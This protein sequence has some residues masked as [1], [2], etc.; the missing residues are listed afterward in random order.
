[1][2]K[3]KSYALK[4]AAMGF[5]AIATSLVI[6]LS[7]GCAQT[8]KP[9]ED[10][11]DK[12][13]TKLDSQ[14][15]K[16]GNFEFYSDN[17][18]LYPI[19][20]PDN[21]SGGTN[22][23]S[24]SS[25]SGVIDTSKKRWD[26]LTDT[27]LPKTLEDNNDLKSDDENKKD[28]NGA[29]TDDLP[30][31]NPHK[32]T[33]SSASDEDKEYIHNPYTHKYSY[34]NQGRIIDSADDSVVTTYEDEDGKLY[35][36]EKL[37]T[38]L[39]S[40]V[41]MI[42][43][44][45]NN[46]YTGTEGYFSSSTTTTLE[47]GTAA[48]ISLWVKT[49]D[50]YFDG[51]TGTRT[52]V[53]SER[54]AYIKVNTQVGGNSLES[55]IIKNIDT[56]KVNADGA[57]NGWVQYT[58]YVEASNFADTTVSLTLGLGQDD[59][60]TV[61]G[62]AFF[63]DVTLTKY[64]NRAEM[65]EKCAAFKEKIDTANG[66]NVSYPLSPDDAKTEFRVDKETYQ[67]NGTDGGYVERVDE[68]NFADR[69]FFIDLASSTAEDALAISASGIT[70]GLTVEE[71]STGKYVSA[72]NDGDNKY[73]SDFGALENGAATAFIPNKLGKNGINI[74]DDLL[75]YTTV[76][77]SADWKLDA[78]DYTDV[79]TDALN[80][81]VKLPG[82]QNNST[83]ALVILSARGAGYEAQIT[84][85]EKF[86]LG[87][88][89][90]ALISFWVKTSDMN[91]ASAARFTVIDTEDKTKKSEFSVD[92]TTEAFVDIGDKE[93]VYNG[94]VKCFIRVSNT[95]ED[96]KTFKIVVNFGN[97]SIKG[98]TTSSYTAGW[99]AMTNLS[100]TSLDKDVYGYSSGAAHAATL[101]FTE[102]AANTNHNFD[103]EL[104]DKNE[105]KDNLAIPSSYTGV[106]GNSLNIAPNGNAAD[107]DDYDKTNSNAYAGILN[108][109]NFE[110][111]NYSGDWYDRLKAIGN[112]EDSWNKLFDNYT[113]QP[114]LIVNTTKNFGDDNKIYNYGY[115]GNVATVSADGYVAVSVRVK[116]SAGAIA[117]VYLVDDGVAGN[118]VLNY[119]LP[120][121]NF[122]YDDDGNILKG[123]PDENASA[124]KKKENIAYTLRADGLYEN[125]DG[126]LY[127]NIYN[128]SK[129][130]DIKFEHE[131][132][133]NES[134]EQVNFENLVQGETYY[135]NA[136]KTAYAPHYLIAGG[137]GNNKVYE[138]NGD[139]GGE[140][141]YCYLE[142]N[143]TNKNKVVYGIDTTV[144]KLRYDNSAAENIPYQ[145]TIDTTTEAGAKYAGKWVTVTFYIHGGSQSKNY[146]L[147]LWSGKRDEQSSYEEGAADSYV[148]FDYSNISLDQSTYD[149]LV[150]A[151]TN[152]ILADYR[153][154]IEGE[155]ADNDGNIADLE[156]LADKKSTLY[157]Y[158]AA[159]YTFSLYDSAAFIPFNAE[160][161]EKNQT[162][163]SY[164][165]S[166]NQESLAILKVED[167]SNLTMSAFID[168][169]VIDKDI[170]IIGAPTVPDNNT[171]N[172][173]DK[174]DTPVNVWLLAASIAL[175]AAIFVAIAAIFI[176][177]FVKKHRRKKTAGKNSYNFNKNKRYVKKYVKAN[178]EA[179]AIAEDEVDESLLSDTPAADEAKDEATTEEVATEE[180]AEQTTEESVESEAQAE[181]TEEAKP[182]GE[183]PTD[184]EEK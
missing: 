20:N 89:E 17:K 138:Y 58:I 42:H 121:Y 160:T 75:T 13:T 113:V 98:T 157:N 143:K 171:D 154:N 105:I 78:G 26:Y 164:S 161:A 79:L 59:I 12:T 21:W 25:M 33:E 142:N 44:Y 19:S 144:A 92:S 69:H 140:A 40:S 82:V 117:N 57:D 120:E 128:L 134:G 64:L 116:A 96:D 172:E 3:R 16:N 55:F 110:N 181:Q 97:T 136:Q 27:T 91:G 39:E 4:S 51:A 180:S 15:I 76:T 87:H 9:T 85:N 129:Y 62:Y 150:G 118:K 6:G 104:G 1:M 34:D 169:S 53:E 184:D 127:A 74:K 5:A 47:A 139:V 95:T 10:E 122:W 18:G 158:A 90:Y 112:G 133:Y 65:E 73:K 99:M 49:S 102:A 165:Y 151:Y 31:V 153:E 100:F 162:G 22:G 149:G 43:N 174:N 50:L 107:K 63:D 103:T 45:R 66:T 141:T 135:A 155:L 72:N 109:E 183:Q 81:A 175:V 24:S 125:G 23:N 2:K 131:T 36:D 170:E 101:E 177:D 167:E 30:Y 54:G 145:F 168:Y 119:A 61:E 123:E 152:D 146:R 70:A 93:N 166:D 182:E 114:L 14:V 48:E 126:K 86:T 32:A 163:Y 67:T 111:N 173:A 37:E 71:T 38:P 60:Y 156:N 132:F 88:G 41:L 46:Y 108:K 176:R 28:Y 29:L 106:Y 52:E 56:E 159:Y 77:D 137:V 83:S 147:E 115:Y 7:A 80:T 148:V 178:G 94:W 130:Y 35:L 11:D 179:P 68:N 84:N 8:D 124:S